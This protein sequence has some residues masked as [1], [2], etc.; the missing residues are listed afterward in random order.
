MKRLILFVL[1]VCVLATFSVGETEALPPTPDTFVVPAVQKIDYGS[2]DTYNDASFW[3][4][5]DFTKIQWDQVTDQSIV[6]AQYIN[7]IPVDKIKI[8]EVMDRT[9]VTSD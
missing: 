7:Q 5:P 9:Q 3:E 4:N 6:P 8:E 2:P 1:L